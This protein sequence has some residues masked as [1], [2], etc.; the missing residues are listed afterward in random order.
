MRVRTDQTLSFVDEMVAVPD[1]ELT[2]LNE[3]VDWPEIE[4][5]LQPVEGDYRGLSLFKMLLLQT[6]HNLSDDGIA[7]SIDERLGLDSL[8]WF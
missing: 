4:R 5:L 7:Q 3:R 8:L 1:T 6:W 2:V